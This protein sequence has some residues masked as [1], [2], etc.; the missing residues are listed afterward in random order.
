[1]QQPIF[2]N[3]LRQQSLCEASRVAEYYDQWV[4]SL[5]IHRNVKTNASGPNSLAEVMKEVAD[6]SDSLLIVEFGHGGFINT[7]TG[8]LHFHHL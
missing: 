1:M 3:L 4:D 8:I 2:F 6:Q 7:M 5:I